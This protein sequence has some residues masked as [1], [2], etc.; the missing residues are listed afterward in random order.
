M[1]HLYNK[2]F[3]ESRYA[4]MPL[5]EEYSFSHAKSLFSELLAGRSV[6]LD[7]VDIIVQINPVDIKSWISDEEFRLSIELNK[8]RLDHVTRFNNYLSEKMGVH[9]TLP[10][11]ANHWETTDEVG[12]EILV[13][14]FGLGFIKH[15]I[16][17]ALE[18][19]VENTSRI[20]GVSCKDIKNWMFSE[21]SKIASVRDNM[22][23]RFIGKAM[24]LADKILDNLD[25][26]TKLKNATV[27]DLAL[28]LG[29]VHDRASNTIKGSYADSN[30][31]SVDGAAGSGVGSIQEITNIVNIMISD[32]T[33]KKDMQDKILKKMGLYKEGGY[34]LSAPQNY[35]SGAVC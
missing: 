5:T 10:L 17:L 12:K 31:L 34:A 9:A 15:A 28:A 26:D 32:E 24:H 14:K 7:D 2:T 21:S 13:Q 22:K 1:L 35:S 3:H 19:G 18:I 16:A 11:G 6:T 29:V 23:N 4:K 27:K 8:K 33:V 30:S 20:L 25:D